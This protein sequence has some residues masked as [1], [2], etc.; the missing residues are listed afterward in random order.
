MNTCQTAPLMSIYSSVTVLFW[1][2]PLDTR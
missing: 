2:G 1:T